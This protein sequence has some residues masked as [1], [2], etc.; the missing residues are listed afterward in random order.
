MVIYAE[1]SS[2]LESSP[3]EVSELSW[4]YLDDGTI[5]EYTVKEYLEMDRGEKFHSPSDEENNPFER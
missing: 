3:G 5:K 2:L 4:H 1:L